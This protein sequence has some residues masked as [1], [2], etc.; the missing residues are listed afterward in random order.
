VQRLEDELNNNSSTSARLSEKIM[1]TKL[2]KT[3][4]FYLDNN[5]LTNKELAVLANC[6][7]STINKHKRDLGL[8]FKMLKD[9]KWDYKKLLE[10]SKESMYWAGFLLADGCFSKEEDRK[11][12]IS[13]CS[14]L[15][16]ELHIIKFADWVGTSNSIYYTKDNCCSVSVY[17]KR[18]IPEIMTFWN[19]SFRKTYTP[20]EIPD[21]IINHEYFKYFIVGLID[22]DGSVV[23]TGNTY[24]ISITQHKEQESFLQ[25]L[26]S[27]LDNNK[28][29]LYM[30]SIDNTANLVVQQ[31]AI[32]SNIK[33]W[34]EE[35]GDLPLARKLAKMI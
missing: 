26:N 5:N 28:H 16:D 8:T 1:N 14:S 24:K 31:P 10:I 35:L 22:G 25:V 12:K 29:K 33:K 3:A 34:Y 4:Q 2:Y 18:H 21:Y 32:K 27:Y 9:P 6:S 11:V 13:L 20:Y 7:E 30:S 15:L 23:K 19:F 17:S